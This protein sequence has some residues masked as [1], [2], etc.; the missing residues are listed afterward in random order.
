MKKS[1]FIISLFLLSVT[2]LVLSGCLNRTE[3]KETKPKTQLQKLLEAEGWSSATIVFDQSKVPDSL[4]PAM[5]EWITKTVAAA[6]CQMTTSDYEDPEDLVEQVET[7]AKNV[8]ARKTKAL[9]IMTGP[10]N[11]TLPEIVFA[12]DFIPRQQ[13]IYDELLKQQ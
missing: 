8:F 7:T 1:N 10:A 3:E 13:K 4:L 5:G 2:I 9:K 12:D 11:E 6:T